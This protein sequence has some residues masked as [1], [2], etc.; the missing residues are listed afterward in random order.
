[1]F[2]EAVRETIDRY[3]MLTREDLVLVAV[4]GGADSIVLLHVLR[5]LAEQLDLTLAVAH[6]D[7][8]WRGE[9]STEDARFVQEIADE[10]GLEAILERGD[11][12][13]FEAHEGLGRE[14]AA[15]IVR[16]SFLMETARSIDATRIALGHTATDR[17]E[18]VLFNLTRGAGVA[19]VAGIPPI[20]GPI[21]RPLIGRTRDEVREFAASEGLS[22]REDPTNEDVAFARNRIRRHVMPE[23]VELNPRAIETICRAADH[24]ADAAR[25]ERHLA[26]TL[27]T[28]V[29][30]LEEPNDVRL[31]RRALAELPREIL[32]VV[33]REAFRRVRGD[34]DGISQDH[35]AT[36]ARLVHG[37]G[38]HADAHLPRL[39]ARAERD[40]I[41]LSTAPF[42]TSPAWEFPVDLGSADLAEI[43]LTLVLEIVDREVCEID[44]DDRRVEAADADRIRFPLSLRNRRIGDRFTPLGMEF[45]VRLKDFLINERIPYSE[46]DD[47]PL[48]CDRERIL[49]VV[50][51]RLSNDVRITET[52][53]RVLV[54]RTEGDP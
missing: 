24:A 52:T 46:R 44:A 34:L 39:H 54:M 45:P 10:A 5:R 50:G 38:E 33:L 29:A 17:A 23:L 7:H 49:W 2:L 31:E 3:G 9:E 18:T 30:V 8:G 28:E 16:R 25:I 22:W 26:E 47:V 21:I 15:R 19:G 13:V 48:L 40:T 41:A 20:R 4:S 1:M 35:V 37:R 36:V 11:A 14:G 12:G 6:L 53:R 27:W 42:P 51:H 43:G 32:G